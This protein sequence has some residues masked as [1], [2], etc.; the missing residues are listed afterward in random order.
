MEDFE[1]IKP[2]PYNPSLVYGVL[3][4][5]QLAARGQKKIRIHAD[6]IHRRM[7]REKSVDFQGVCVT[8]IEFP[9]LRITDC[10]MERKGRVRSFP[11]FSQR[12]LL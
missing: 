11:I 1:N 9:L 3:E 2:W 5:S 6:D 7:R 4:L 8:M 12:R 10:R